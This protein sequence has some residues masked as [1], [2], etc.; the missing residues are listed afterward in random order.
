[1]RAISS[2]A[3]AEFG[4][5]AYIADMLYAVMLRCPHLDGGIEKVDDS[6]TRKVPGVKDVIVINGPKPDEPFDGVLATGVAVIAENTW[7]A[8][9]G[10][11]KL[12]VDWSAG[13]WANESTGALAATANESARQK[14]RRR[15]RAQRRRHRQGAQAV[16][17]RKSKRVTRC[18]SSRTCRWKRWAR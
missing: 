5:D 1:M 17:H 6:E 8:L 11:E 2:P 9:K 13:P 16:A 10:R 18:R 12:K 14:C 7:A 4:S 15:R 3:R